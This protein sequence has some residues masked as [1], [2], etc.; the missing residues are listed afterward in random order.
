MAFNYSKWDKL[1]GLSSGDSSEDDEKRQV[2]SF[3]SHRM[4]DERDKA[5]LISTGSDTFSGKS[6]DKS[7]AVPSKALIPRRK[8]PMGS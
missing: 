1:E 7:G 3:V 4:M 5:A 6:L 8:S 2:E